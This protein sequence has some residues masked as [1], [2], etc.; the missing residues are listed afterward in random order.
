MYPILLFDGVCNLCNG[1]VQFVIERDP[2]GIFR[3]ASLQSEI[4]QQLLAEYKVTETG[5]NSVILIHNGKYYAY[6]N[7]VL[8]TWRLMGGFWQLLYVFKII[9]SFLRNSVYRYVAANRYRWFGKEES[10]WLP[11]PELK[12]RFL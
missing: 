8:E 7:A 10:C 1:A 5:L 4:G 11:T 9:P 2:K 3:F 6:S 12:S